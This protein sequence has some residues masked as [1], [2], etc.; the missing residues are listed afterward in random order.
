MIF[1]I[2]I[3][4]INTHTPK[5][6]EKIIDLGVVIDKV[7]RGNQGKIPVPMKESEV[8]MRFRLTFTFPCRLK[9]K[10]AK[11]QTYPSVSTWIVNS[12]KKST[13]AGA[14]SGRDNH[15][16]NGVSATESSSWA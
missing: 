1:S 10:T 15:K 13:I 4:S 9:S 2:P 8:K 11:L 3:S 14:Q 16:T 5:I 6:Q 12:L 7:E